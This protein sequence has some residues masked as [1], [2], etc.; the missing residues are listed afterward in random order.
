ML[1]DIKKTLTGYPFSVY[2]HRF[3]ITR[4]PLG[5]FRQMAVIRVILGILY[6]QQQPPGYKTSF[7]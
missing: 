7:G 1:A 3:F 4:L 5:G 6:R 2:F